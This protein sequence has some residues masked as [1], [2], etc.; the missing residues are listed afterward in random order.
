MPK[1]FSFYKIKRKHMSGAKVSEEFIRRDLSGAQVN[2]F[3][4]EK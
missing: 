2:Y 1:G 4:L 3:S